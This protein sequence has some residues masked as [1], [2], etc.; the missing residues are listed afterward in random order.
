S[1]SGNGRLMV[2]QAEKSDSEEAREDK[3]EQPQ[4]RLDLTRMGAGLLIA[5]S[6]FALGSV[7]NFVF[8]AVHGYAWMIL[9]VALVKALGL[10]P[11]KFEAC[12][13]QWFQFVMNNLTGVLLVG[14]GIAYTNLN[15][16]AAAFSPQYLLLVSV[17]VL[18]AIIGAGLVGRL[19]GFFAI[20]SSITGGLCMANMGGTG[21]VAVLSAA[22]RMELMPFA[23]VSSRIG[24]AFMLIL[25][26]ILIQLWA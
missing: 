3:D 8:P 13:Y 25:S 19:V 7:V 24:G 5:T 1:L 6:F 23:Q 14:I 2:I 26:S 17:T 22:K 12:C 18:G 11:Q 20:E 15:E 10:L 16:V 9:S 4:D 21:D